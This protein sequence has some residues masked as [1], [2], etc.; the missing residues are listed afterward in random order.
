MCG[1]IL[2]VAVGAFALFAVFGPIGGLI[3]WI[4]LG[5]LS[6]PSYYNGGGRGYRQRSRRRKRLR[7]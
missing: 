6:A 3:V 7:R 1:L 2:M 5:A 4:L